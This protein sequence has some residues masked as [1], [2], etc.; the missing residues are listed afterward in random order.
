MEIVGLGVSA[1]DSCL[2]PRTSPEDL[3]R[4]R[5]KAPGNLYRCREKVMELVA[6]SLYVC[7]VCVRECLSENGCVRGRRFV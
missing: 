5:E 6:V 3:R 4:W 7:F 1:E 2:V